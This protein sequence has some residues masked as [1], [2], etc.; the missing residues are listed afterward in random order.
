LAVL[1]VERRLAAILAADI[2]GYSRLVE[3]D[4]AETLAA[5]KRL[6]RETVDPLLAKHHGRIVKLMGDGAIV[7]FASVVDAVACAVAV[8]RQAAASQADVPLDRRIV[9]RIGVNL[10]D[11]VVDGDDLLGDGVNVAA[12]L[13]QLCD[14]GGVLISG[15]AFDQLRG[16]IDLPLDYAGEQHV[17]NITQPVRV[18][19]VRLDG[20]SRPWRLRVRPYLT[21]LRSAVAVVGVVL[22]AG[23]AWWWLSPAAPLGTRASIA[24]LPFDNRGG[25]DAAGRLADG[26]TEEIITDLTRFRDLEV[27]ARNSVIIYKDKPVDIQ[28]V[29]R[30][31]NVRYVL[32]GSIQREVDRVR[33]MAQL[34][35]TSSASHVWSD[36]WDRPLAD[37]FDVQTELAELVAAKLGGYTGTIVAV[38]RDVAKRKRPSDLT[39]Y[40]FYLLGIEAKHRETKE[41]VTEA[42]ALLK[43]SIEIDPEF[44]RPWTGLAWCYSLLSGWVGTT[45]ELN[46]LTLDA[47][48]RAVDLDPLDAEA[49][50]AYANALGA[51][52]DLKQAEVELAK[53]LMLNPNSADILTFYASWASSFGKVKE[54]IEASE[55]AIRLNPNMPA[56]ALGAYRYAFFMGGR[57]EDALALQERRPKQSYRQNDYVYKAAIFA[58]LSRQDEAAATVA[59]ALERFPGLSIEEFAGDPGWNAA[60]RQRLVETMK[61]AGFPVCASEKALKEMPQLVRLPE[62]LQS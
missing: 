39:A 62:C 32:K 41:S 17:K 48:R 49:H 16:K 3:R 24:V 34:I 35:E 40:D 58:V 47:A 29:G 57:Y 33:I 44:A 50:A 25:D 60:E 7:E 21:P 5:I 27:I 23:V 36:R 42:I 26:I 52:G 19:R 20:S 46:Q 37:I 31:L 22:L 61:K 1:E 38:D 15:T 45:A 2:V 28:E 8:Q 43:K 11:V 53:A 55:R 51:F 6:R 9:F 4:E 14:P 56:W 54:G 30:D 59:E 10:G 13:E 18:Y 12:R